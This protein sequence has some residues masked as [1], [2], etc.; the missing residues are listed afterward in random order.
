M[1][2]KK[3]QTGQIFIL[4]V[5][6][7][8]LVI[9]ST[10]IIIGASIT[11]NQN[12]SR[13]L[14][15]LKALNLAEA[16]VDRA[17]SSLNATAG[18]YTGDSEVVI[19]DGSVSVSVAPK[20]ANIYVITSTGYYPNKTSPKSKKTVKIEVSKGTGVSFNYGVQVGDGGLTMSNNS[21][22]NGSIYSNGNIQMSNNA[23]ITGDVYVAGGVAPTADQENECESTN[24]A[25]YIFGKTINGE[26]RAD[27]AQSFIP[28]S[29][30]NINRVSLRLKK[31][32]IPSNATIRLHPDING[33]PNKN[34]VLASGSLLS[35][36]VA[37]Q[38]GYVDI[39]FTT[40][41]LISGGT[42]YWIS[43]DS[44][45]DNS[46]YFI[47]SQDTAQGYTSGRAAWSANWQDRTP[48]WNYVLNGDL[49]F[50][51]FAGGIATEIIGEA[52][53]TVS[54][55]THANTIKNMT[56]TGG[57]YYQVI[58]TSNA[59]TLHPNSPDPPAQPMPIS[60]T[61]ISEWKQQSESVGVTTGDITTCPTS[62]SGKYVGNVSLPIDCTTTI[63]T[64]PIW[65]TGNLIMSGN[66]TIRLN[67]GYGSTSG[68]LIVEGRVVL[69]NNNSIEGSG[70]PG[71]YLVLISE[72]DSKND[73]LNRLAI[74]LQN[75]G[76]TGIVYANQGSIRI[77]NNNNM[78]EVTGW[79]LILENN[80]TVTYDQGLASAFF[81]SGP[82]GSYSVVKGT[83][84][85]K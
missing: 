81:S 36:L 57:A 34:T 69:N 63:V 21:L 75:N 71:S 58:E 16:G 25:D 10:L 9:L 7:L 40:S 31:V 24:C 80:V 2:K 32:G 26:N 77:S 46:N 39:N 55:D 5:I 11:F 85:V 43:V 18:S 47:W 76:N 13:S 59:G 29:T 68:Y 4:G 3:F 23:R 67:S 79:K 54:G 78:T 60:S 12:A 48:V 19:G 73:P 83:Y 8:S 74:D 45:L 53:S 61:I 72:F 66:N 6:V 49:D 28:G 44:S 70:Q 42:T 20:T 56:I 38:Y 33:Q 27:V 17:V 1:I 37:G 14:E 30:Q 51:T 65:I 52:N 64:G 35:S 50:K 84:Q 15:G 82:A 62:L 22:V 41:P